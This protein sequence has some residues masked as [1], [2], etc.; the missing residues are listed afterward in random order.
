MNY[1]FITKTLISSVKIVKSVNNFDESFTA[2]FG[3]KTKR[4]S[5]A[6]TV[7]L[8][9]GDLVGCDGGRGVAV[10]GVGGFR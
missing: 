1:H 9:R 5:R 6:Y 7:G 10:S 2:S 3:G 4:L 8:A